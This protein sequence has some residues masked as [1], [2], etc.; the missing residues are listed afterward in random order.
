[1]SYGLGTLNP[2]LPSFVVLA[3]HLPYAG[4]QIYDAGFLPPHHQGVRI[5]PGEDPVP[6]LR[7]IE[8]RA[9]SGK[10]R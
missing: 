1:M 9:T 7:P 10:N 6:N 8:Q 4:A 2:N 5:I 3:E